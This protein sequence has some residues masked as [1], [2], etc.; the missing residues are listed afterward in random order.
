MLNNFEQRSSSNVPSRPDTA[1]KTDKSF[2]IKKLFARLPEPEFFDLS[3]DDMKSKLQKNRILSSSLRAPQLNELITLK[4][5]KT[6]SNNG[7]LKR[8]FHTPSFKI[9]DVQVTN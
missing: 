3:N 9:F 8:A 6:T 4:K 7:I 2:I 5:I 1:K